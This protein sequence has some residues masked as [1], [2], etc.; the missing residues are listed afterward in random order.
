MVLLIYCGHNA[1][2]MPEPVRSWKLCRVAPSHYY[3]A[4]VVTSQHLYI[5]KL[6]FFFF[7]TDVDILLGSASSFTLSKVVQF[8][9]C[10]YTWYIVDNVHVSCPFMFTVVPETLTIVAHSYLIISFSSIKGWVNEENKKVTNK[11]TYNY[12]Y[13]LFCILTRLEYLTLYLII[14][15]K[16]KAVKDCDVIWNP[17]LWLFRLSFCCY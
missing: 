3:Y 9:F 17:A 15:R 13:L 11:Y 16:F 6:V 14:G 12:L 7:Y 1:L 2:W 5:R 4:I 8:V 10:A